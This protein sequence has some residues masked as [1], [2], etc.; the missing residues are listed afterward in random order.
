MRPILPVLATAVL[1]GLAPSAA[2][3]ETS[4]TCAGFIDAV[5]AVIT[6]QG[7]WCLRQDLSTALATG[8]AIQI[9]TNNVTID[10]NQFKLG[11]LLAGSGTQAW[12]ILASNR[13]NL[14]VRNC[15]IR[16]FY[17]GLEFNGTGGG[18]LV[19]DNRFDGNTQGGIIISGDDSL[20]RRNRVLDTGGGTLFPGGAEGITA[21]GTVDAIDNIVSGMDPVLDEGN[22]NSQ[23]ILVTGPGS[24]LTG[25][26]VRGLTAAGTGQANA[27]LA[28][29][30]GSELAGNQVTG[31][32][33]NGLLCGS[34]SILARGNL[35][36][37]FTVPV[38]T[39][40]SVDNQILP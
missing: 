36:T 3:A 22:A 35:A 29:G 6:T 18:H 21:L 8:A 16:G 32:G 4:A 30:V 15:N 2:R 12:G 11:G 13:L 24:R 40:T 26:I 10:C 5:P 17:R 34:A 20:V 14:T 25:N 19:E 23:G 39:C 28:F 1:L 31:P 33:N 9:N 37:G 7:V 38:Q 27:I